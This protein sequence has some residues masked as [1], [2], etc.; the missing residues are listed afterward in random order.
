MTTTTER[1]PIDAYAV[2]LDETTLRPARGRRQPRQKITGVYVFDRSQRT[3]LCELTPSYY[4]IYLYSQI[5]PTDD[6]DD[7]TRDRWTR[8][9]AMSRATIS[10]CTATI[11]SASSPPARPIP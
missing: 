7:D 2:A 8:S 1:K 11:S 9:T 6:T 10:T 5:I 4:L 3:H